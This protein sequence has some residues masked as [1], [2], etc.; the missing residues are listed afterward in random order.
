M[1]SYT[2][3]IIGIVTVT[4]DIQGGLGYAS[5][6]IKLEMSSAE[7]LKAVFGS[8]YIQVALIEQEHAANIGESLPQELIKID[9]EKWPG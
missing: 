1:Y 8:G 5:I 3:Q 9:L 7:N 4:G 6:L 2:C